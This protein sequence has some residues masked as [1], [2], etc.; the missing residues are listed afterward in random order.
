[1]RFGSLQH[2]PAALCRSEAADPGPS[3]FGLLR[4]ASPA[5]ALRGGGPCGLFLPRGRHGVHWEPRAPPSA[6][7]I[8]RMIYSFRCP[9]PAPDRLRPGRSNWRFARQRSWDLFPFA[10]LLRLFE[11]GW[12][13]QPPAH[14]P[15]RSS[16]SRGRWNSV[17]CP[18]NIPSLGRDQGSGGFGFWVFPANQPCHAYRRPRYSF[19]KGP[20]DPAGLSCHGI[21]L[22]LSGRQTRSEH[23]R[24]SGVPACL[25]GRLASVSLAPA[26]FGH[27]SPAATSGAH[28]L[29]SFLAIAVQ[30]LFLGSFEIPHADAVLFSV[31]ESH[32]AWPAALVLDSPWPTCLRFRR[33]PENHADRPARCRPG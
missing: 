20:R 15:F 18:A 1:M 24:C 14:L 23:F 10:V 7:V 27:R 25:G 26:A 11:C 4:R 22:P 13:W 29:L 9:G 28:P 12:D 31:F 32:D 19:H 2:I 16:T 33:L 21:L 17:F 8:R 3:R 30:N 5:I 6:R